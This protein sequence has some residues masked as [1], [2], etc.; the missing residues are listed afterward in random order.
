MPNP[1]A[2][3]NAAQ[4]RE[5]RR[6]AREANTDAAN[7]QE[8]EQAK[9]TELQ[10]KARVDPEAA[11][12]LREQSKSRPVVKKVSKA[13]RQAAARKAADAQAEVDVRVTNEVSEDDLDL[14]KYAERGEEPPLHILNALAQRNDQAIRDDAREMAQ[15]VGKMVYEQANSRDSRG[16]HARER[17]MKMIMAQHQAQDAKEE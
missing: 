8:V 13:E 6:A 11:A 14:T 12:E 3:K 16:R 9:L 5:A 4:K 2:M 17:R 1:E 15:A 7:T 10:N